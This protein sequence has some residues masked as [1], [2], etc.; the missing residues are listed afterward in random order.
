MKMQI[1]D[2]FERNFLFGLTRIFAMLIIFGILI[3]VIFGSMLFIDSYKETDTKIPIAL[4]MD[5]INPPTTTNSPTGETNSP[6][7]TI[8]NIN[9]LPSVKMPF[10]LQKYFNTPENLQTLKK[11]LDT[12][13]IHNNQEIIDEMAAIVT[14]A[15][16]LKLPVNDAIETYKSFK[17]DILKDAQ[18]KKSEQQT[19]QLYY[20][21]A[22][23]SGIAL[24][25][26]FS[27]ILVLLA[28]E[29]NTRRT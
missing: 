16:K 6:I 5:I 25:A 17:E 9:I 27:L 24:I 29:R 22:I 11:W 1:F 18:L 20:I 3:A 7:Q 15:E 19:K 4:I 23:I 12:L 8:E 13:P 2:R 10:I 21:G 26:L 14:E 28:I